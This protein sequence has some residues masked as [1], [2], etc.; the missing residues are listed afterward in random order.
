MS[1]FDW[2]GKMNA[3]VD[4]LIEDEAERERLLAKP[5]CFII[6]GRPVSSLFT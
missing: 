6:F 3:L 4:N 5:T 2:Q 1:L